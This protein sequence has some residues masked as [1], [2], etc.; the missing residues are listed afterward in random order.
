MCTDDT[1][2]EHL[3]RESGMAINIEMLRNPPEANKKELIEYLYNP[4]NNGCTHLKSLLKNPQFY[5]IREDIVKMFLNA[6]Y[7]ILW[8]RKNE[9]REKLMLDNLIGSHSER[10]FLEIRSNEACFNAQI[11]PLIV[12]R[13]AKKDGISIFVNHLEA[14]SI[15]RAQLAKF[16]SGE[17][18][19]LGQAIDAKL[20]HHRLNRLGLAFLEA[21]GVFIAKKLPFYTLNLV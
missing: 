1:A 10:A 18:N 17:V 2:I 15:R 3:E 11:A 7:Q 9:L 4:D 20:M 21:T 14:A 19:H 12:P 6:F 8:D 13:E 5:A 16:F